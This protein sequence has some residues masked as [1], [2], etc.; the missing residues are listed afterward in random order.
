MVIT[1]AADRDKLEIIQGITD[2]GRA[3]GIQIHYRGGI[4]W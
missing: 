2:W 4:G 1:D 3:T